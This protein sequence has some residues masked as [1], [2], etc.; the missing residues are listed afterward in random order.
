MKTKNR[1]R[2]KTL[3]PLTT[4]QLETLTACYFGELS[5]AVDRRAP[6]KSYLKVYHNN[7]DISGRLRS[8]RSRRLITGLYKWGDLIGFRVTPAG[9][10]ELE[11][12]PG[13]I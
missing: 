12:V 5:I 8:L 2:E 9:M 11:K 1:I 10:A 6:S 4:M 3:K 7:V 13:T